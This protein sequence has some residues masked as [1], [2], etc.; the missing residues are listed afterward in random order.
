MKLASLKDRTRDGSLVVV[1]RDLTRFVSARPIAATLRAALDD[2]E[3]V[4]P[5]LAALAEQLELGSVPSERFHEN[6][7][8][9]P[10]PRACHWRFGAAGASRAEAGDAFAAPRE[11]IAVGGSVSLSVRAAA[12]T[13]D[14][15]AGA[16]GEAAAG[17]VLLVTLACDTYKDSD[18]GYAGTA[19]APVAVTPDELGADWSAGGFTPRLS[20]G[21]DGKP[22]EVAAASRQD[23]AAAITAAA[24]H[25]ALGAGS[26]IGGTAITELKGIGEGATVRIAGK[27]AKVHSI[28]GAIERTV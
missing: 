28:F 12:L 17:A 24:S 5:R 6:D 25:H 2:W 22:V 3:H 20:V 26:V 13:D 21:V 15:A 7:V 14:V 19:F 10:L 4:A 23:L 8:L 11:A 9:S 27:D 16:S 1:S 18:G